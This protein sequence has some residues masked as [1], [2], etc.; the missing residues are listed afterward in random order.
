MILFDLGSIFFAACIAI[1]FALSAA[2]FGRDLFPQQK[3]VESLSKLR[4][5]KASV[6][7][8]GSR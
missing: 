3:P 8:S 5:T 2:A 6:V 4:P 7:R 1:V